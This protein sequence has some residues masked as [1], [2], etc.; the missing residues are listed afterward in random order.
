MILKRYTTAA[1]HRT[2]G[3][4]GGAARA[5][6]MYPSRALDG[7]C[8]PW[9]AHLTSDRS[10]VVSASRVHPLSLHLSCLGSVATAEQ[11]VGRGASLGRIIV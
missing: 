11:V 8:E 4:S 3:S 1:H 2:C 10:Q 9:T 5:L 6:P 7:V